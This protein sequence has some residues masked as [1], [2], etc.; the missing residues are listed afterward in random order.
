MASYSCP[1]AGEVPCQ[2][3]HL[4]GRGAQAVGPSGRQ[5]SIREQGGR[6]AHLGSGGQW[7]QHTGLRL[8]SQAPVELEGDT[9]A[10]CD[11]NL[12]GRGPRGPQ[13]PF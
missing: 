11:E 12:P 1:Q 8:A 3:P 9:P 6:S 5:G 2:A 13:W 4:H 10:P 7:P